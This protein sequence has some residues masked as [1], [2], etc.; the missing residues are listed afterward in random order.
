MASLD[1]ILMIPTKAWLKYKRTQRE[2]PK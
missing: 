2:S 1:N